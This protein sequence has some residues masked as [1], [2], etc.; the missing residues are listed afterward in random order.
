MIARKNWSGNQTE[1]GARAQAV[2]TSLLQTAKQQGKNPLD[3][4]IELLLGNEQAKILA[5]VP[6][7]REASRDFSP[8]PPG[9]TIPDGRLSWRPEF[10]V[11]LELVAVYATPASVGDAL[12]S[13]QP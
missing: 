13:V 2:L 12:A 1:K 6:P 3:L 11:P 10:A 4:L 7:T 8:A 9:A 5:L